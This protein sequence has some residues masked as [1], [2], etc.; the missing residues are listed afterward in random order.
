MSKWID[1]GHYELW[2]QTPEKDWVRYASISFMMTTKDEAIQH[3]TKFV[4]DRPTQLM[5]VLPA[6]QERV[7][8]WINKVRV[9]LTDLPSGFNCC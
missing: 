7:A 1:Q 2:A 8:L 9:N 3:A 6:K 5:H 4:D